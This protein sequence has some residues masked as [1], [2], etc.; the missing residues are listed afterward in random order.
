M[1][2]L[3]L[4]ISI[5]GA[6]LMLSAC[7]SSSSGVTVVGGSGTGTT[8]PAT[9]TTPPPLAPASFGASFAAFFAAD[10]N[11]DAR[12]PAAA[13]VPALNTTANPIG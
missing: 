11:T 6:T 7:G 12:V 4:S 1:K 9:G 3:V 5:T 13:D 2:R 10:P 8:P